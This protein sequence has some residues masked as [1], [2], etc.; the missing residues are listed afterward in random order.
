MSTEIREIK[1]SLAKLLATENITV[2]F[3]AVETASF[4]VKNRVL[5]IP[6]Y[7]DMSSQCLDLF[8]GHEVGHALWT[9]TDGILEHVKDKNFHTF[10][11]VVEDVR[12][13]R[14]IQAKYPGLK[15]QFFSAYGQL[16][17]KDFFGIADIETK[18]MLFIDRL[19]LKAKLGVR[20]EGLFNDI[21]TDFYQR[22]QKTETFEQVIELA[23]EIYEYCKQEQE[24]KQQG[25]DQ[26]DE[27]QASPDQETGEFS[28]DAKENQGEG[29]GKSP[30]SAQK[31]DEGED[32]NEADGDETEDAAEDDDAETTAET[33][34]QSELP[35]EDMTGVASKED[36]SMDGVRSITDMNS[37]SNA[38]EF[39]ETD[40][41]MVMQY[42]ELP[43]KIDFKKFIVS[44][45]T[46]HTELNEYW[47]DYSNRDSAMIEY[48]NTF[49]K[50]NQ[51]V[52]NYLNKEFE[53]KKAAQEYAKAS[54]SKTGV[55]NTQKLYSYK[56]N[57]DIFKKAT[58]FPKGKD[59]GMVFF[60]DWSG[61]MAENMKGTMEQLVCLAMFCRKANIPFAAYAFTSEYFKNQNLP[62]YERQSQNY[63]E[64]AFDPN[65]GL[66]ELFNEKM[67][68]KK[69][70]KSV[71]IC[72]TISCMF[73]RNSAGDF[74][75]WGLPR[76]YFLSGTP[77]NETIMFASKFVPEFKKRN[78]IQIVN[79][80][81]L[82]DG[83]SHSME[84]VFTVGTDLDLGHTKVDS[85]PI[86]SKN[87]I[88]RDKAT[89]TQVQIKHEGYGRKDVTKGL[90]TFLKGVTGCNLVGFFIASGS[91]LR[92]A[93]DKFIADSDS[94]TGYGDQHTE[95]KKQ[96]TKEKSIISYT[97][98]LDEL[99]II[100]GGK[101]LQINDEGL[102][103][104]ANPSRGQLTTAFKKMTKG[105]LQNR[106]ILSKF[107]DKVAA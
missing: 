42:I 15:K 84:G 17:E 49:K 95:F 68:T 66:L 8:V 39:A 101:T 55:I 33:K 73:D 71:E 106:V 34:V 61:S 78:N 85:K 21:E 19:N 62:K 96:L 14:K 79:T 6:T 56:F 44:S 10:M 93:F 60:L 70:N 81:F 91:D 41:N 67:N 80:V 40:E 27:Q 7:K 58:Q 24:E 65:F 43:K 90:Y 37:Q 16:D 97:S 57:E 105:K 63:G 74:R 47:K 45:E 98:G 11:N 75:W 88:V 32:A 52:I 72:L 20:F 51:K 23:K 107:I 53:M 86:R 59:H 26:G 35:L 22:S 29:S 5:L 92:Y 28:A 3:A 36:G 77:L 104:D 83:A 2:Q 89:N 76:K 100:K 102:K 18:D 46:I 31:S 25:Q 50:R 64:L 38:K 48:A 12:I 99:Y 87:V 9:P 54:E 4:D 1:S 103:V 13:E 69:F 82:T 94:E 30:V